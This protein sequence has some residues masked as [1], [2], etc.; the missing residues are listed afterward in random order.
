MTREQTA[1]LIISNLK[2]C[3]DLA[4]QEDFVAE[5]AIHDAIVEMEHALSGDADLSPMKPIEGP[6]VDEFRRLM[7][8]VA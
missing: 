4:R 3:R 5:D 1:R 6:V 2:A 7:R 8:G